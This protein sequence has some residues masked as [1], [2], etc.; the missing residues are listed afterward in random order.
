MEKICWNTIPMRQVKKIFTVLLLYVM[1]CSSAIRG[2]DLYIGVA[3]A[4]ISPEFPVALMGQFH[5]RVAHT[6]KNKLIA[7]VVFL[8]S[9]NGESLADQ[10]VF[11][12]CDLVFIPKVLTDLVRKQTQGQIPGL[13]VNKIILS[14]THTH[15]SPVIES[16]FYAIPKQGVTQP[17]AYQQL[18]A[19]RVTDAIVKAWKSRKSGSVSWALTS[20][21]IAHNR[22]AVYTDGT[23]KMY[24]K[25]NLPEFQNLEGYEDHDVNT[26][27][28]WNKQ[29]NLIATSIEV[30]CPAQ[31]V[32]GD[33]VIDADYWHAV[34]VSLK[35]RY[36][37]DLLVMGWIGA[38]G[39]QSP[40]LMYRKKAEERMRKLSQLSRIDAIAKRI[41]VAVEEAYETVKK[42]RYTDVIL[43]HKVETLTLPMR[44]V[45]EA[46][47]ND[48]KSVRDESAAKIAADPK[49]AE[50]EFTKTVWYGDVVKRFESQKTNPNPTYDTEIHVVRLGDVA[51]CTNQFELFTDFGIR[52]QTRSKALQTFIIQLAGPGTYL[53]TSKAVVGEV[54]AQFVRVIRLD[55]K[56]VSYW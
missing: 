26:L 6:A 37:P 5:L 50:R 34:R 43:A 55:L 28:F 46:E 52:I 14:A 9:R 3:A 49:A 35:K 21:T 32:E 29:G 48:S 15:T 23:A 19:K 30:P 11:V 31:E 27:F 53:P 44:I 56:V 16:G 4:D 45:T 7:N 13:D 54:I 24:G 42:D 39:D 25:T 36:G 17:E 12:S 40:H 20:A 1:S 41:V 51:I 38:A 10:T 18:F 33:S 47:Y 2:S 22:R 8:E